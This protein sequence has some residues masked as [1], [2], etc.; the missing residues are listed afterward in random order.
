MN[1]GVVYMLASSLAFSVMAVM[2]KLAGE[3]LPNQ[4]IVLVR[5]VLSLFLSYGLIRRAG[6][7]PLGNNRLLL[8]LRGLFG[9][10]ALSCL[11]YSL[12]HLPLAEATVW[13]SR[14]P[15]IWSATS[16]TSSSR[17]AR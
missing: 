10:C 8:L 11:V 4:E 16:W 6:I 15:R 2:V 7:A 14:F 13:V 1:Q 3:R 9:Y 12:T 5:A 17:R